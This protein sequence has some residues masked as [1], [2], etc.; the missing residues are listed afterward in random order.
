MRCLYSEKPKEE[1]KD[2]E[3]ENLY[4]ENQIFHE[5]VQKP[6]TKKFVLNTLLEQSLPMEV[7]ALD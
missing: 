6:S 2:S 5:N 4:I 3:N 1:E 7:K